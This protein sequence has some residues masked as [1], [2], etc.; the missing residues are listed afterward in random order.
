MVGSLAG[1]VIGSKFA[2]VKKTYNVEEKPKREGSS[3]L[4]EYPEV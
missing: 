2:V 3:P 4:E 1:I